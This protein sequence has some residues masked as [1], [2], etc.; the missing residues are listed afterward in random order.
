V[1]EPGTEKISAQKSESEQ[2]ADQMAVSKKG[3]YHHALWLHHIKKFVQL[4]DTVVQA[5]LGHL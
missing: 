1:E 2:S 5:R 4:R 3:R